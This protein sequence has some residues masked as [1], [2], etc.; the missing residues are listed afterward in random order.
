MSDDVYQPIAIPE[1]RT[2]FIFRQRPA[3]IPADLRPAWRIGLIVLLLNNCCRNGKTSLT[4]LHVLSWGFITSDG[5]SQL[6]LAVEGKLSPDSL[7]IRFEPFLLQAVDYAVG[8]RIILR[9][10]GDKVELTEL[11][12]KLA[13][14][15][16]ADKAIFA[17]EKGLMA[18]IGMRVTE[19]LIKRMFGWKDLL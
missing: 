9:I 19:D 8:E 15:L 3:S 1:F 12:R 6:A 5:R 17:S 14:E 2:P 13:V 16:Q 10:G 7:V 18:T 11:G 4:R